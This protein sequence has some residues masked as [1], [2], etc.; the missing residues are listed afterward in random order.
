MLLGQYGGLTLGLWS[1]YYSCDSVT[2]GTPNDGVDRWGAA[3]DASKIVRGVAGAAHSWYVLKSPLMNGFNFYLL[4]TFDSTSD[5]S[6]SLFMAK[7][8]FTGGTA[9]ANPTS[10]DSWALVSNGNFN[11][12]NTNA[13]R[14]NM[15]LSSTGDFWWF[16]IR[17]G[18][19][20]AESLVSV[21]APTG[22]DPLDRYP[23]WS[24]QTFRASG[25]LT[26]PGAFDNQKMTGGGTPNATLNGFGVSASSVTMARQRYTEGGTGYDLLTGSQLDQPCWLVVD[27]TAGWHHRGRLP[28][29]VMSYLNNSANAA[30]NG[31]AVN[32]G[33]G[34][35]AV[36]M[37]CILLPLTIV[38]DLT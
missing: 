2:A 8:S 37:G 30:P 19:S 6:A 27:A 33:T 7:T 9:T 36:Q 10:T 3:F 22:C 31:D 11:N 16:V 12:G 14:F 28:D 23:I 17:A 32:P 13:H 20:G 35:I 18:Q 15:L 1:T 24:Y 34:I 26:S 38:P 4:I 5:P 21:I 25:T 29:C